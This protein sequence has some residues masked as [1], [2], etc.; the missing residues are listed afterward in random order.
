M[1][2][3]EEAKRVAAEFEFTDDDVRK[4][5]KHFIYQ[6]SMLPSFCA[7][8]DL[9]GATPLLEHEAD[10]PLQMRGWQRMAVL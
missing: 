9:A 5:V 8:S 7:S 4:C 6:M 3:L 2:L 10:S 1:S